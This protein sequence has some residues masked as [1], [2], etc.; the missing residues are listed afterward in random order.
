ML[1]QAKATGENEMT[2]TKQ[3]LAISF[4]GALVMLM[5]AP[6][7]RAQDGAPVARIEVRHQLQVT[8]ACPTVLD[9]LPQ[10]LEGAWKNIDSATVI[11]VDFK[12]VGSR[13]H[14][15]KTR[16]GL[17]EYHDH[18]RRAV[19]NLG[20]STPDGGNY[21]V[22]FLVKFDYPDDS[23]ASRMAILHGDD[24]ANRPVLAMQK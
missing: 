10:E 11:L 17:R 21:T 15:V 1:S 12:L 3:C 22:R 23:I 16:G 4:A 19:R 8:E 2:K 20:C 9:Q 14:D 13:I 24:A 7:S 5:L 6:P 18:V